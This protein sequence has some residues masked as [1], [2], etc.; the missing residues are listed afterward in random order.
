MKIRKQKQ[1]LISSKIILNLI[2][3]IRNI[4][5]FLVLNSVQF[6]KHFK[7]IFNS[8]I[9]YIIGNTDQIYGQQYL[10]FID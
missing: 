6:S 5:K 1:I 10:D 9:E 7:V 3:Y 8:I 4:W 2:L